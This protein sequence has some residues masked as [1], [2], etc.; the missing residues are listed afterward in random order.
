MML[1]TALSALAGQLATTEDVVARLL[2]QDQVRQSQMGEYSVMCRY[3][4]DN[5]SRHAEMLVHWTRRA[6]GVKQYE[7]IS[8]SGDGGV[9]G[10]VFHKLL[11]AEVDA[12]K[13]AQRDRTRITPDNYVFRL[14]G[15]ETVRG[16]TAYVLE[17]EPKIPAKYLTRGRIWVDACDYAVVQMEG[18]PSHNPSFWTKKVDFVQTFEKNGPLWLVSSNHSVTDARLF[19]LADLTLDYFDYEIPRSAPNPAVEIASRQR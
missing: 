16:R 12:S 17:V 8:E 11:D 13:P 9:R 5:K 14:V 1:S 4:L 7:I 15:E 2:E 19:G 6:D 3:R 18:A 10:H